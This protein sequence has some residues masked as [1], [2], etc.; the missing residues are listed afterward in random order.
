MTEEKKE[1]CCEG[2]GPKG[3]CCAGK[4]LLVG[5]L[6]GVLLFAGGMLFAKMQCGPAFCPMTKQSK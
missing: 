6:V 3:S 2:N 1:G 4:K 5:V